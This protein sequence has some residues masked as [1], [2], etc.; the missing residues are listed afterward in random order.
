MKEG[1]DR[2][3]DREGERGREREREV[4]RGRDRDVCACITL[5]KLGIDPQNTH[6][7][8]LLKHSILKTIAIK[9]SIH[10]L[11][12][13]AYQISVLVHGQTI[14]KHVL[15]GIVTFNVLHIGQPNEVSLQLLIVRHISPFM[16]GLPVVPLSRQLVYWS[17]FTRDPSQGGRGER[18][19][20]CER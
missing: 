19:G 10:S 1:G 7:L 3:G 5:D 11:S 12:L 9:C 13:S 20:V 4:E 2:E 6:F 17:P 18:R 14:A 16:I 8:K 15:I